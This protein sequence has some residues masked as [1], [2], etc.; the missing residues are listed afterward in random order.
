MLASYHIRINISSEYFDISYFYNCI[1]PDLFQY[2]GY[3]TFLLVLYIQYFKKFYKSKFSWL[4]Q[5][6]K[7]LIKLRF[8]PK[9][10]SRKR[11]DEEFMNCQNQAKVFFV[12]RIQSKEK[13][14]TGKKH[15]KE[16]GNGGLNKKTKRRF[17]NWSR[18][19]DWDGSHYVNNMAL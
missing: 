16:R 18:Y 1:W 14:F 4:A 11:N 5:L 12:Y 7:H 6:F 10:V 13:K 17:L 8:C 2:F 3:K 15:C 19:D 9:L